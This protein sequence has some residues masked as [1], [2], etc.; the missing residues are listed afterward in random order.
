[1]QELFGDLGASARERMAVSPGPGLD[2]VVLGQGWDAVGS[3]EDAG[4]ATVWVLRHTSEAVQ[5]TSAPAAVACAGTAGAAP[6]LASGKRDGVEFFMQVDHIVFR[7]IS[8]S[9]APVRSV[10]K[11]V[12]WSA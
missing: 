2:V 10:F 12:L 7:S 4:P 8:G 5:A 9:S 6:K 11:R 1:M 3:A